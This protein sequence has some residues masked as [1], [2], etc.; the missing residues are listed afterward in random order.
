MVLLNDVVEMDD[1]MLADL[2]YN[3]LLLMIEK[4]S[5]HDDAIVRK[6]VRIH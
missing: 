1:Q 4:R 3:Q 5:I 2:V 6:D